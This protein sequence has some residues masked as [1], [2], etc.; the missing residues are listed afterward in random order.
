MNQ[1]QLAADLFDS[2]L[3]WKAYRDRMRELFPPAIPYVGLCLQDLT[4]V[5]EGNQDWVGDPKDKTVNFDK[6]RLWSEV[7]QALKKYQSISYRF[8]YSATYSAQC[9]LVGEPLTDAECYELSLKVEPRESSSSLSAQSSSSLSRSPRRTPREREKE[10]EKESFKLKKKSDVD[11][12]AFADF[13][14][15]ALPIFGSDS[16]EGE[17]DESKPKKYRTSKR[18]SI[19]RSPRSPFRK[20]K[21]SEETGDDRTLKIPKD[22]EEAQPIKKSSSATT[23]STNLIA[24]PT[25]KT[26]PPTKIMHGTRTSPT[27]NSIPSPNPSPKKRQL[28]DYLQLED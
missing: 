20:K 14:A 5:E 16:P 22:K 27:S 2:S 17:S 1:H 13:S 24:N 23:I 18:L 28:E 3:N 8:D 6:K 11:E 26:T 25:A 21:E 9:V 15:Y 4:F 10:K 12:N 7:F 19:S